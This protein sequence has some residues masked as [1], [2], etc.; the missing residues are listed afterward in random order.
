MLWDVAYSTVFCPKFIHL[1][2]LMET[3]L[4]LI[5]FFFSL[6]SF[7]PPLCKLSKDLKRH[8][9]ETET[10]RPVLMSVSKMCCASQ[11]P[12]KQNQLVLTQPRV[13]LRLPET[14]RTHT[15]TSC[16]I[17]QSVSGD[18]G[19]DRFARR[20]LNRSLSSDPSSNRWSHLCVF[21]SR[22]SVIDGTNFGC[23]FEK[24]EVKKLKP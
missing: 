2:R 23:R 12:G 9:F 20:L 5:S 17:H 21:I 16:H 14:T 8:Q 24:V 13:L 1:M 11:E 22:C 7:C 18:S 6:I 10:R 15:R 4:I 3:H 19:I